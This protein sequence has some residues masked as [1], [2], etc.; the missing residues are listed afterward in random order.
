MRGLFAFANPQVR[1]SFATV[2]L[3][4]EA[5]DGLPVLECHSYAFC[6]Q[7]GGGYTYPVQASY[8]LSL[9]DLLVVSCVLLCWS[10]K[11]FSAL[12]KD[13]ASTR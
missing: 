3:V 9:L 4:M 6:L 2:R 7:T 10:Y 13:R 11:L 12:T 8:I 1:S 5:C